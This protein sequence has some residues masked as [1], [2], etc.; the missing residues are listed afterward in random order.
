MTLRTGKQGAR[1]AEIGASA[2]GLKKSASELKL[3]RNVLLWTPRH[4]YTSVGQLA[5]TYLY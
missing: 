2:A 4:G 3:K 5:R 1:F